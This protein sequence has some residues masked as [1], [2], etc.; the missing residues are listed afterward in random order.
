MD[1]PFEVI[2]R[3]LSIIEELLID[4]KHRPVAS[5]VEAQLNRITK[6]DF[7]AL[8]REYYPGIPESTVRQDTASLS[9]TKVGKRVLFDRAEVEAHLRSKRR[10]SVA[11]LDQQ[12]EGQFTQQH[13][14]R[15]GRKAA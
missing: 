3:R 13:Q 14:R 5:L 10:A 2:D 6:L 11:E 1:N 15:G 9:R 12:A 8:M 4:I 7:Q